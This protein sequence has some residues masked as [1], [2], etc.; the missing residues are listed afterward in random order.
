M[1]VK[2]MLEYLH[3]I[4]YKSQQENAWLDVITEKRGLGGVKLSSQQSSTKIHSVFH[5]YCSAISGCEDTQHHTLEEG[6]KWVTFC[7]HREVDWMGHLHCLED[8]L[9]E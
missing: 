5:L 7:Q 8:V 3:I 1:S 2:C 9:L 6:G 4:I